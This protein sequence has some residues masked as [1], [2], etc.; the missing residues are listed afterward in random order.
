[1]LHLVGVDTQEEVEGP[2]DLEQQE[3]IIMVIK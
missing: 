3:P 1:M 2:E